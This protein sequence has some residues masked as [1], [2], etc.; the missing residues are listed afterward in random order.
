MHTHV[1]LETS[2]EPSRLSV[3]PLLCE[4]VRCYLWSRLTDL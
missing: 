3:I 1:M 4:C 2:S